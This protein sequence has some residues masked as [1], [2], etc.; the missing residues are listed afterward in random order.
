MRREWYEPYLAACNDRRF[1]DLRHYVHQ[2][3]DGAADGSAS[4]LDEYVAG[5]VA[6]TDAF[7]DYRWRMERLVIDGQWIGAIVH[8]SGTH[9]HEFHGIPATGRSVSV[10]ELVF[11]E[12]VEG[13][14][15]TCR[16]DLDARLRDLLTV[17]QV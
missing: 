2:D 3:V 9:R 5:V 6:I 17:G 10:Q 13:R 16:G 4:G 1:D 15:R 11:Y 14:L 12:V 8:G 7:P